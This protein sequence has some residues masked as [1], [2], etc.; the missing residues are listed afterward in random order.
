MKS[1]SSIQSIG[2]SIVLAIMIWGFIVAIIY[3]D[4]MPVFWI[5]VII[6]AGFGVQGIRNFSM[7]FSMPDG[8]KLLL[9]LLL[10]IFITPFALGK[11]LEPFV[12]RA[13]RSIIISIKKRSNDNKH[14]NK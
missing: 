8:L 12:S 10:G 9:S 14:S 13:V 4:N 3:G 11:M 6:C 2:I 7:P 1:N 5:T